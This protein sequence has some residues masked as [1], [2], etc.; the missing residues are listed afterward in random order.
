MPNDT[1]T[2]PYFYGAKEKYVPWGEGGLDH[3]QDLLIAK[4]EKYKVRFLGLVYQSG[5][6]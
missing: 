4:T 3:I 1:S 2:A 5:T 6:Q